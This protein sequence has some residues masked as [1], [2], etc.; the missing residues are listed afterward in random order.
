MKELKIKP[1]FKTFLKLSKKGNLVPVYTE[2]LADRET[3]VSSFLKV[4]R[5]D[6]AYLL[7]SVESQEK[8]GRYSFLS[9]DPSLVIK[10]K[11]RQIEISEFNVKK[12]KKKKYVTKTN[13]L[14]EIKSILQKYRYV[15]LKELP[16]FAGGFVGYMSYDMIRFFE[17]IPDE[18]KDDLK[19]PDSIFML[20][21]NLLVFDHIEHKIRIVSNVYIRDSGNA[22]CVKR[23]Y[24]QGRQNIKRLR[25]SLIEHKNLKESLA[26]SRA[27]VKISSNFTKERFCRIV[28]KA[29]KYIKRGDVIQVVLSQRF[30]TKLVD[31]FIEIYRRLRSIN[32]SPYMYCLKLGD[33]KIVGSSPEMLVRCEDGLIE[34]RPIA[35][36]RPRGRDVSEDSNLAKELLR[37][38]KERAEHIMLVDLGRN[39][40]GR[41]AQK[42]SVRV[43]DF[44]II[45]KYSHV[46]HIVSSVVAKLDK[47]YDIFNSL[48]SA[49]P[50]GTVAGAP[51]IRAMEI[52]DELENVRRG[53]YAGCI[54]YFSFS[55][56]LDTCITIRTVVVKDGL[57]YVQAGAGIVAD[58]VP[59]REYRETQNKAKALIEA[60]NEA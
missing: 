51:K 56:N 40:L 12:N 34:T 41:V 48:S 39:D 36:T 58:S 9:T 42:G 38:K 20:S 7:E 18:N 25:N 46:M 35:G 53:P 33:F 52:I 3:P 24:E 47:R 4:C 8:I 49:F 30:K 11:G 16:R 27:P 55:G 10:S 14:D 31:N 13:P 19:L 6:Y 21:N 29:K 2:L 60:I 17:K 26:K 54:G 57:C 43:Q 23:A 50:A 44:M 28:K 22:K 37:D 5:G 32:P 1:D 15:P 45:E 59:E